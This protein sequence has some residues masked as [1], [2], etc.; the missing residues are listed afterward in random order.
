MMNAG[1][2]VLVLRGPAP[3]LEPELDSM[4]SANVMQ[5]LFSKLVPPYWTGRTADREQRR[6][7]V[8]LEYSLILFSTS[9]YLSDKS[10]RIITR[11]NTVVDRLSLEPL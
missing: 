5:S 2:K 7:F 11:A 4:R 6:T 10:P 8:T 1:R 3:I 9:A